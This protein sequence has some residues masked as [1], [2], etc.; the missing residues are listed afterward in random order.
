MATVRLLNR[1]PEMSIGRKLLEA[2][3]GLL[4]LLTA[5]CSCG[6]TMLYSAAGG[7]MEPWA[8]RQAVRYGGAVIALLAVAMIDIRIWFR[9][10]YPI[11]FAVL[12]LLTTVEFFG[13]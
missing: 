5:V 3:W 9:L 4:L 12:A 1:Q 10:A 13:T 2:N 8:E 6:L 11:Y 7:S